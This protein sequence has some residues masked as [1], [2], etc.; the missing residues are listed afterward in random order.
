[1]F[2][3]LHFSKLRKNA[4]EPVRMTSES[5]G[6]DLASCEVEPVIIRPQSKAIIPTGIAIALPPGFSGRIA[7]RSSLSCKHSIEVGAG[8]ID[9]DFRGHIHVVLYN[10]SITDEY[11]VME[12][13]RIAQLLIEKVYHPKLVEVK[14]DM[15]ITAHDADIINIDAGEGS[16]TSNHVQERGTKG[17]GNQENK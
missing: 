3:Q 9:S 16:S 2:T 10:H 6:F 12:G 15:L 8:I 4:K 11:K 7:S 5:S 14:P 13:D 1:M 17:L